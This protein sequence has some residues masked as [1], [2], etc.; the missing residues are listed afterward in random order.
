MKK[1]RLSLW[2]IW[3]CVALLVS[4]TGCAAVQA[5]DLMEGITPQPVTAAKHLL[6]GAYNARVADFAV[7]LFRAAGKGDNP[8]V[9]PL[10]VL[11]ALGMTANGA[12]GETRVQMEQALGLSADEL[13]TYLYAYLSSL[14]EEGMGSLFPA[15]SVWLTADDR[16]TVEKDFLQTN[17]DYYGADA[18]KAPFNEQTRQDINGWV[19]DKTHGMIPQMLE[20]MDP[21]AVMVLVNAL[22]FEAAWSE[23][24]TET[25]VRS[26]TFYGADG[27]ERTVD[28]MYGNESAYIEDEN[29]IG[30]LK[31]YAGGR[32]AFAAL[33]PR[34]NE[35]TLEAY[36]ETL[37][38]AA[39]HAMLSGRTWRSVQTAVPRMNITWGT[40]M[41]AVLA[42]MGMPLAFD[43][44]KADF[45]GLGRSTA[46]NIFINRVLH[47]TSITVGEKGTKAG[48]ATA[49]EM[50]D[51][52]AADPYE[53]V[54]VY[55]TRP[56]V[57]MLVDTTTCTPLF[58][59]AMHQ[60]AD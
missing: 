50:A 1:M 56:F 42:A 46:G 18:Y 47:K 36:M 22:A 24:Y 52:M 57:Y 34:E 13:N 31:P 33:L 28:F 19:E 6:D 55:L 59:G 41:A 37:D 14:D 25:Q 38:G 16:L 17:A 23:P 7:R 10:S 4:M 5:E 9:S 8:L 49:V 60:P 48:A 43:E 29:A 53:N 40:D 12:K 44:T 30:F 58:I 3:L 27:Q 54:Q 35:M 39:L 45:T 32:Y 11:C 20:D 26:G 51:K 15:N 21:N 2:C